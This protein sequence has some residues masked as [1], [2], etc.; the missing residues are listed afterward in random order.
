MWCLIKFCTV[1]LQNVL[2][3]F[4][5]SEYFEKLKLEFSRFYCIMFYDIHLTTKLKSIFEKKIKQNCNGYYE[6]KLATHL[7][8][9]KKLN[10]PNRTRVNSETRLISID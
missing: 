4:E 8:N 5:F 3:K 1:C 9:L 7:L 2:L 6:K 10:F